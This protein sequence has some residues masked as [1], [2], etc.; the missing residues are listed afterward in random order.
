MKILVSGGAGFIGSHVVDAYLAAGHTVAVIDN[1]S[2]GKRENLNTGATF[3]KEDIRSEQIS[4]IFE[5][6]SFDVINHLAAQ[7]DLRNSVEDPLYDAQV[8]I[9]GSL[10]L[11]Q[12]AVRFDIKKIIFSSTG[13]AIYGE[14]DVFPADEEH[15]IRP[16]SPYGVAKLTVEKY[17]YFYQQTY[18]LCTI[19]LR[20]AN[21]YGPRQDPHGEAG[22]VAIFTQRLL[23]GRECL[24]HGDGKQTRDYVY[25]GDVVAANLLALEQG[26]SDTFNIGTGIETDVNEIFGHLNTFTGAGVEPV[27]GPAKLGEQRRSVIDPGKA[28]RILGWEPKVPMEEGMKETVRFFKGKSDGEKG[29]EKQEKG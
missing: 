16:L 7:I 11:F 1:L 5:K 8:N 26:T 6:E 9:L 27:H 3:Y 25:V 4:D 17:L 19:N 21:V 15:P 10:N 13:G 28:K 23:S 2:S 20:Y 14:Q 29:E 22:V 24:I 18:G 12:H